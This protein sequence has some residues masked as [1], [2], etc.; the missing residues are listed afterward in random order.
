VV[1][2][3]DARGADHQYHEWRA[4]QDLDGPE[5]AALYRKHLGDWEE[6]LLNL[7]FGAASSTFPTRNCGRRINNSNAA[8][9]ILFATANDSAASDWANRRSRFAKS[10]AFLIPEILTVGFRAA[11]RDLQAR[12]TFVQRQGTIETLGERCDAPGAIH[13]CRQSAS[14]R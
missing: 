4:H 9:S 8:S 13:F 2:R 12:R 14:A 1:G 10:I 7:I 11:I 6:H 5:F 3:A